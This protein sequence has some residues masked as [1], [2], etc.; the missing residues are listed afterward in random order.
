MLLENFGNRIK[1]VRDSVGI[2]QAQL[3]ELTGV[4]R[5]QI[6]RI[7]NGQINPTLETV[8]KLST[9]LQ[10]PLSD[11]FDFE[12]ESKVMSKDMRIK[13]FLKWAGGKTQILSELKVLMPKSFGTYFEPFLGGGAV[14]FNLAPAKAIVSDYNEEL[15]SAYLCFKDNNMYTLMVDEIIKH[16][17]NHNEKYYYDIRAM[18]R[19]DG[20]ANLPIY[21][22]AARLIYLNKSC[23]NGLYRVNSKG[24]F[25]VPSGKKEVVKAY[26]Q[27]LFDS[28]HEYLSNPSIIIKSEDFEKVIEVAKQGDFVYFDPPYDSFE[29]QNNFTTYTKESFGRDEQERLSRVFKDL[30]KK[31]VYVMLSNHNTNFIREL[32]KDFRIKVIHARRNINSKASGR[33]HVEEVVITN[34]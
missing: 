2:S 26:N 3:S 16:E 18:D 12:I 8:Y 32:Y 19:A 1:Y 22:K 5:E 13:P 20:Y 33:G 11:L 23:F 21:I 6:S 25:N 34:Y 7:E 10:I 24:Y 27:E 14:L 31:G 9:A 28:L 30:D 29:E 15:I 17:N 4:V